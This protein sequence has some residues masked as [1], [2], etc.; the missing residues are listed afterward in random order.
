MNAPAKKWASCPR[1]KVFWGKYT[2]I[3]KIHFPRV[4]MCKVHYKVEPESHSVDRFGSSE[5]YFASLHKSANIVAFGKPSVNILPIL[6]PNF[7]VYMI[8]FVL[9][10]FSFLFYPYFFV[11]LQTL[12]VVLLWLLVWF[13]FILLMVTMVIILEQSPISF[14]YYSTSSTCLAC[15]LLMFVLHVVIAIIIAI[16]LFIHLQLSLAVLM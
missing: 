1:F 4:E 9:F 10:I 2:F 5:L 8:L 15:A 16:F 7:L 14:S 13:S 11:L 3:C 6:K 12:L